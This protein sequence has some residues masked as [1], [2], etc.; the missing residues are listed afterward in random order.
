MRQYLN[1]R[2]GGTSAAAALLALGLA[3]SAPT[4]AIAAGTSCG[5]DGSL[6]SFSVQA[7]GVDL[8]SGRYTID[9]ITGLLQIVAPRT[10]T[11][12]DG[13]T[14]GITGINGNADPV[15]GFSANANTLAS[16]HS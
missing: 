6:C 2:I 5:A 16:G 8:G 12:Q 1:Y 3:L 11:L 15:L 9:P 14:V 4:G 13:S 7:D 10:F